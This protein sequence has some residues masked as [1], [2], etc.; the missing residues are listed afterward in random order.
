MGA[1]G[2]KVDPTL[3]ARDRRRAEKDKIQ[4]MYS[5]TES[6]DEE[7]YEQVIAEIKRCFSFG[8]QQ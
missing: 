1:A 7:F 3:A 2:L 5:D 4:A 6:E 8:H